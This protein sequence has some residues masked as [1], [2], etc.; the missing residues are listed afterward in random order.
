MTEIFRP[1]P[2]LDPSLVSEAISDL[3]T[4]LEDLYDRMK[5]FEAILTGFKEALNREL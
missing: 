1:G 4:R 2:T 5:E 3:A